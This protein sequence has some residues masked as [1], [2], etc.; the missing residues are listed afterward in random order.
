MYVQTEYIWYT[1]PN[2]STGLELFWG[3]FQQQQNF[4]WDLD[5]PTNFHSNLRFLEKNSLHIP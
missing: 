3:I 2:I 4:E 1:T 5:P